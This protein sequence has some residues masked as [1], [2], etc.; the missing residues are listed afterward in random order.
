[1]T[2]TWPAAALMVAV[3]A[4]RVVDCMASG[5][6]PMLARVTPVFISTI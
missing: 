2:S 1:M 6:R 4:A 3:T 5:S